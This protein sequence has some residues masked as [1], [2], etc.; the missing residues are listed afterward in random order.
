[1]IGFTAIQVA[2]AVLPRRIFPN[3]DDYLKVL[4]QGQFQTDRS[5]NVGPS[6]LNGIPNGALE[7]PGPED[8]TD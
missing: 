8:E 2:P 6:M 1:M 3:F 5:W 4:L 7:S